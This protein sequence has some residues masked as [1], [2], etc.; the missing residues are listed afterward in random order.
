MSK[1]HITLYRRSRA[2]VVSPI[3]TAE[4]VSFLDGQRRVRRMSTGTSDLNVAKAIA[5]SQGD[6]REHLLQLRR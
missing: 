5:E 1:S 3:W 2:G 4:E 6:R